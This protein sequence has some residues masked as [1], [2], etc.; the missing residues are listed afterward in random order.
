M[1]RLGAK[2]KGKIAI[3]AAHRK[4]PYP[5]AALCALYGCRVGEITE[6]AVGWWDR[7]GIFALGT[8]LLLLHHDWII[9][10]IEM[11]KTL[12]WEIWG[13]ASEGTWSGY[14]SVGCV[15]A[16]GPWSQIRWC[17][18]DWQSG[19]WMVGKGGILNN[20]TI[21]HMSSLTRGLVSLY[22]LNVTCPIDG[23]W[24]CSLLC[25]NSLFCY[26]LFSLLEVIHVTNLRQIWSDFWE[27]AWTCIL[28]G[29]LVALHNGT[30]R[31]AGVW[32]T[33]KN[34]SFVFV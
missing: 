21:K 23:L 18:C 11:M 10:R 9:V 7:N 29:L 6:G 8:F 25:R 20:S 22:N 27:W 4:G 13:W 19:S 14:V 26:S 2:W 15:T 1:F 32:R 28:K 34:P 17:G 3:S 5:T 16:E 30:Q 24:H 12:L 33:S 31:S